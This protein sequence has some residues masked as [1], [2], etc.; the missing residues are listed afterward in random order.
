MKNR[1]EDRAL[2]SIM[3]AFFELF[4]KAFKNNIV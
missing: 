2:F 4:F 1:N 3:Q